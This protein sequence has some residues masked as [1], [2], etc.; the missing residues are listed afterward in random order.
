MQ[1]FICPLLLFALQFEKFRAKNGCFYF[2]NL[3][4]LQEKGISHLKSFVII[5][6]ITSKIFGNFSKAT[7]PRSSL[8]LPKIIIIIIQ[9][10]ERFWGYLKTVP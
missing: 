9:L 5:I 1:I 4:L 10:T 2:L 6:I 7:A 8:A 3:A